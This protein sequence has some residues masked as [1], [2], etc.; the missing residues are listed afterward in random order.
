MTMDKYK[1]IEVIDE[2]ALLIDYGLKD[3]A[4]KG[5]TLRIIEKGKPVVIDGT[6]YGTLDA[7]KE[8]VEVDVP[9]EHFSLC[10]KVIYKTENSL[11]PLASFEKTM[12]LLRPMN[13]DK[14]NASH[15]E[16]PSISP[17]EKGDTVLLTNE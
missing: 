6:N 9:Y 15:R 14:D 4:R 7:V 5:N 10:R 3:G 13:V 12:R 8:V 11:N 17:I 1:V 2:S 16:L